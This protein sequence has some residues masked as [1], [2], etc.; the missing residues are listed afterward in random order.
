LILLEWKGGRCAGCGKAMQDEWYLFPGYRL[1]PVE[2]GRWK[3][4]VRAIGKV[5]KRKKK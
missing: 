2:N 1:V 3:P 4:E 5:P